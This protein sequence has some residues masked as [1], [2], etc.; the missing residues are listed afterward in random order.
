M[1]LA[2]LTEEN[3]CWRPSLWH[4]RGWRQKVSCRPEYRFMGLLLPRDTSEKEMMQPREHIG[5]CPSG[6]G[7]GH[8]WFI[9]WLK[10]LKYLHAQRKSLANCNLTCKVRTWLEL[11]F[12]FLF[13]HERSK[14]VQ[15]MGK[16]RWSQRVGGRGRKGQWSF[17][18]SP[19]FRLNPT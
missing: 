16:E 4:P 10:G 5:E 15:W 3:S 9:H 14:M 11:L 1:I 18:P 12:S 2:R 7:K 13:Y 6:P 17:F 19:A 8:I